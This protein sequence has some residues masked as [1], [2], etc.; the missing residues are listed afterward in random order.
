[1]ARRRAAPRLETA[2]AALLADDLGGCLAGRPRPPYAGGDPRQHRL[3]A[4]VKVLFFALAL[5][6]VATLWG[7]IAAD[8]GA[9]L[10]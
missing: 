7:A 2:D 9:S 4:G 10:L 3:R 8:M 6:G 1:M 5:A